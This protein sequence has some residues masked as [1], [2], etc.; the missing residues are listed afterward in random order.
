MAEDRQASQLLKAR[1]LLGARRWEEAAELLLERGEALRE[2]GQCDEAL[3][4]L[5]LGGDAA[6]RADL[7]ELAV[8]CFAQARDLPC[9]TSAGRALRTLQLV[10]VLVELGELDSAVLLLDEIG[11]GAG[12]PDLGL[13][14]LDA[15]VGLELLRG[16]AGRARELL[17]E[18]SGLSG[19]DGEAAL[20]FRQGQVAARS[21][22]FP[23]AASALSACI[24]LVE[25]LESHRGPLGAA[26][27]EL[28]EIA[29]FREDRADALALAGRAAQAWREAGRRS[30]VLRCEALRAAALAGAPGPTAALDEALEGIE[31]GLRYAEARDLHLLRAELLCASGIGLLGRDPPRSRE[32]L[33]LA[34]ELAGRQ[35]ALPLRGRALLALNDAPEGDREA[36][37]Q[38]CLDLV[39]LAPWRCRAYV[40]LARLVALR[41]GGREHALEI[42]AA[43]LCR[44]ASM[45]LPADEARAR[46]LLWQLGA[47]G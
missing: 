45:D 37:E 41:P 11:S 46:G 3:S 10:P 39:E 18:W 42:C 22:D 33:A 23:G 16:R 17:K 36:L 29:A 9:A 5:A 8:R 47:G 38:A 28:A 25:G 14:A 26:L 13:V 27:L 35:G 43:A 31:K 24:A 34:A 40:A 4:A 6:W 15:R 32:R 1:A 12:V 7:P 19:R 30:G 2:A 44:L 20:R 21:G